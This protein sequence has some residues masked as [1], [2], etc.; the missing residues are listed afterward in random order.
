MHDNICDNPLDMSDMK[1][2]GMLRRHSIQRDMN[3]LGYTLQNDSAFILRKKAHDLLE[4]KVKADVSKENMEL[5]EKYT[6]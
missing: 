1:Y 3:P 5:L 2:S 4:G 6:K